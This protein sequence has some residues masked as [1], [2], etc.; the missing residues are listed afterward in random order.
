MEVHATDNN[1]NE[2]IK[3][4]K[5]IV[6]FYADWCMPCKALAPIIEEITKEEN[7]KLVKVNVDECPEV[8]QEYGVMS[9]PTIVNF[10]GGKET[11]R[12]I[13]LCSKSELKEFVK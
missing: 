4:E 12:K 5:V 13:G 7:I 9:I 10:K 6:D 3:E 11:D 1:F 2:L 8:S